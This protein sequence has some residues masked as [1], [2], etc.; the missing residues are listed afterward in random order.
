[1]CASS[2][3]AKTWE[4]VLVSPPAEVVHEEVYDRPHFPTTGIA[5]VGGWLEQ[6][7]GIRPLL[8]D[9]K[10]ERLSV[11]QTVS[12]IVAARPRVVGLSAFTHMVVTAHRIAQRVRQQLPDV[13]LVLGGF[14]ASSLPRRSLEEF[15]AFDYL[16][17]GEGEMAFADLVSAIR[18]GERQPSTPGVWYRGRNGEIVEGGRGAIPPSL[19]ELGFAAWHLYDQAAIQKYAGLLPIMASRGCPFSCNF[20]S[21]PYGHSVRLRSAKHVVDEIQ[22]N[23]EVFGV[24]T[25]PFHDETFTVNRKHVVEICNEIIARGLKLR[26]SATVHANTI[27]VELVRLMKQAGCVEVGLGVESGDER[28]IAAM[29]KGVTKARIKAAADAFHQAGLEFVVFFIIGHPGETKRTVWHSIKFAAELN[30]KSAAF[31]IMV[32]YP[33]TGVWEMAVKGEGG[34]KK[35]SPNWEDYNKQVGNA[36]ELEHLSRRQMELM[37]IAGYLYIYLINGRVRDLFRRVARHRLRVATILKKVA[38]GRVQPKR[39]LDPAEHGDALERTG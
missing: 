7:S 1:M 11:D 32:P 30:P 36:V 14:H 6:H 4:V 37:Q 25:F 26:W 31:G 16:V 20:C 17:V 10:L 2:D 29:H 3:S 34:Y 15:P 28:I 12:R 38:F 27:T 5:Y 22:R 13:V 18:A 39:Q 33:G 21:R 24:H 8:I 35:L 23:V 9:G 19:D